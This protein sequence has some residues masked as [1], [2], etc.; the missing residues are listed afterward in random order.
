[1]PRG[2]V[3]QGQR[4][5]TKRSSAVDGLYSRLNKL[6]AVRRYEGRA[7]LAASEANK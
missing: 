6:R 1:M 4:V 2:L 5:V 3:G 7:K